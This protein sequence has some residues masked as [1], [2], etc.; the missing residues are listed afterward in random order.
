MGDADNTYS[1][2]PHETCHASAESL[3]Y[4]TE[5]RIHEHTERGDNDSI[6]TAGAGIAGGGCCGGSGKK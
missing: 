2:K 1:T 6:K 3:T 4:C 5:L